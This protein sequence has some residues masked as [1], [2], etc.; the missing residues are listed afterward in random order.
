MAKFKLTIVV[1][2][3][4]DFDQE[5]FA[6]YE[7]DVIDGFQLTRSNNDEDV[8]EVFHLKDAYIQNI[9]EL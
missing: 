8:T 4:D 2:T 1:D 6:L 7:D 9:Q 5:N 3:T